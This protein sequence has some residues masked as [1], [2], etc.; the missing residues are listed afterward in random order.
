M[1]QNLMQLK[2]KCLIEI[3][4]RFVIT[5]DIILN[6]RNENSKKWLDLQRDDNFSLNLYYLLLVQFC[7]SK[8]YLTHDSVYWSEI[9]VQIDL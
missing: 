9:M 5:L 3:Y 6:E 8:D 1:P 2:K 7:F 4:N